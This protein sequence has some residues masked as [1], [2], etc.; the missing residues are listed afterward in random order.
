MQGQCCPTG[1]TV[2]G[3]IGCC[4]GDTPVCNQEANNG[5]GQCCPAGST[6]CGAIGCCGGA[7]PVC[8]QEANNG[9]GRC[10]PAAVGGYASP[11]GDTCCSGATPVCG[12]PLSSPTFG[13]G[14]CCPAG[15][16]AVGLRVLGF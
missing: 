16:G 10:C 6:V 8:N 4:G 15:C 14:F 13:P 3:T 9:K 5:T 1:S 7:T 2:C 11:C 12:L